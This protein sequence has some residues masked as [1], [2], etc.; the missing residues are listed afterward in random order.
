MG[1]VDRLQLEFEKYQNIS[2]G[3]TFNLSAELDKIKHCFEHDTKEKVKKGLKRLKSKKGMLKLKKWEEIFAMVKYK[4]ESKMDLT[5]E[6]KGMYEC[7]IENV[8]EDG[9]YR[10]MWDCH[11]TRAEIAKYFGVRRE[12]L[13]K[14]LKSI[15]EK[16]LIYVDETSPVGLSVYINPRY[17]RVG[18]YI[19]E[20]LVAIFN[21]PQDEIV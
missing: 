4:N 5:L 21:I 17:F 6:E 11:N 15:Q 2:T 1:K 18:D 3:E 10:V 13:M 12:R 9:S 20:N 8:V 14:I 16:D 19:K 7:L